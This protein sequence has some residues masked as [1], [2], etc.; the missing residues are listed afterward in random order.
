MARICG[1]T[2]TMAFPSLA[3][4]MSTATDLRTSLWEHPTRGDYYHSMVSLFSILAVPLGLTTVG[5][6]RA[7]SRIPTWDGPSLQ[8]DTS[9]G[10]VHRRYSSEHLLPIP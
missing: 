4:A 9:P 3:Q 6:P 5:L 8:L 7:N 2:P 1:H 10:A